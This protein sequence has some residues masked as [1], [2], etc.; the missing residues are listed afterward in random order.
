M[1]C[2]KHVLH[3]FV[4]ECKRVGQNNELKKRPL[5]YLRASE[6]FNLPLSVLSGLFHSHDI[7]VLRFSEDLK[8]FF[9][10]FRAKTSD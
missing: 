5:K 9:P 1:C 3:V 6:L 7:C 4:L 8:C 10:N 2:Q